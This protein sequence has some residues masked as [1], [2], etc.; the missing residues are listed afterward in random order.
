MEL[1]LVCDGAAEAGRAV[2]FA[3][4]G[5]VV[6]PGGPPLVEVPAHPEP[7]TARCR[8][9][10]GLAHDGPIRVGALP[11][12]GPP[13]LPRRMTYSATARLMTQPA[14]KPR[15]VVSS[16]IPKTACPTP[17]AITWVPAPRASA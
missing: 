12:R 4:Q 13:P 14:P 7:V 5:E 9:V 11:V 1:R 8:P 16:L 3:G 2:A 10:G 17:W 15:S 6:E